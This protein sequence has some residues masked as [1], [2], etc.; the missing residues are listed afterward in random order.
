MCLIRMT[1]TVQ[2]SGTIQILFCMTNEEWDHLESLY[3]ASTANTRKALGHAIEIQ[4]LQ[5]AGTRVV[6][7]HCE[8]DADSL[9]CTFYFRV[10]P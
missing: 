7:T 3:M 1:P 2:Q 4:T 9:G 5:F 6:Y 10:K 8:Y